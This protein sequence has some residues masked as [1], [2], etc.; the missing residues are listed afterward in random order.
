MCKHLFQRRIGTNN[1]NLARDYLSRDPYEK[2]SE[3][4]FKG[5][6]KSWNSQLIII[7]PL[8]IMR[9]EEEQHFTIIL[10]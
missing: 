1:T 10:N 2:S 3:H 4:F 7:I 9:F 8:I 5:P 6:A